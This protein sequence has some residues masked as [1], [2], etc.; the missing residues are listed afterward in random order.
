MVSPKKL[1]TTGEVVDMEAEC[2]GCKFNTGEA[3]SA[4]PEDIVP[5]VCP[6]LFARFEALAAARA[7]QQVYKARQRARIL[8]TKITSCRQ[9]PSLFRN[10]DNNMVECRETHDALCT[11]NN[12]EFDALPVPDN[13]PLELV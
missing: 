7:E 12:L 1:Y 13:C 11:I 4:A 5:V 10:S 2:K 8:P 9:C 6:S 3:C